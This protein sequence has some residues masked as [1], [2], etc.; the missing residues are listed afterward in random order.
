M[1]HGKDYGIA[2]IEG[3]GLRITRAK[4]DSQILHA[5][6]AIVPST[7]MILVMAGST[8]FGSSRFCLPI[9]TRPSR[10]VLMGSGAVRRKTAAA[11]GLPE[12]P[13]CPQVPLLPGQTRPENNGDSSQI[14]A[15]GG[16]V[17]KRSRRGSWS[18]LSTWQ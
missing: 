9:P 17:V 11:V 6:S 8:R 14:L 12:N 16:A 13:A 1:I 7:R 3:S 15:N 10:S 18:P 5:G 4:Y 2:Y